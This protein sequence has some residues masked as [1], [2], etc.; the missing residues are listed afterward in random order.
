MPNMCWTENIK[1]EVK[2]LNGILIESTS[3]HNQVTDGGLNWIADSL[4]SSTQDC[5][6]KYLGWGSSNLAVST[7]HTTLSSEF[8][9]K[10]ITSQSSSNVGVCETVCYIGPTEATSTDIKELAWFAGSSAIATADTG[11]MISR[12]LYSRAKTVLESITV[13][14]VDTFTT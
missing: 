10:S 3:F 5:E 14:R 6:I 7:A 12:V 4:R 11:R 8:G 13:T 9:R 1:I 2:N